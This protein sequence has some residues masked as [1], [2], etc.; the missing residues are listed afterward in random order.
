MAR[1]RCGKRSRRLVAARDV[2][3]TTGVKLRGPEGARRRRATSAS[4]AELSCRTVGHCDFAVF[5]RTLDQLRTRDP[6]SVRQRRARPPRARLRQ[7]TEAPTSPS[8][9]SG[10]GKRIISRIG[11]GLSLC[12]AGSPAPAAAPPRDSSEAA[13]V[14]PLA[15]LG[16]GQP[17]NPALAHQFVDVVTPSGQTVPFPWEATSTSGA[18]VVW[19]SRCSPK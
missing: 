17:P 2:S 6:R 5:V 7:V 11:V 8:V 4:T 9:I 12:C 15:H 3:R 13:N 14:A 16:N 19:T 10:F 1:N 18:T